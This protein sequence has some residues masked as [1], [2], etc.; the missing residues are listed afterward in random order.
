VDTTPVSPAP[1]RAGAWTGLLLAAASAGC[2]A[3][4]PQELLRYC[5]P[6]RLARGLTVVVPGVRGPQPETLATLD[7]LA[8]GGVDGEIRVFDWSAAAPGDGLANLSDLDRNRA[9]ARRLAAMVLDYRARFPGRPVRLVGHSGG[10]GM[11]LFALEQLPEGPDAAAWTRR[12]CWPRR[13]PPAT[14]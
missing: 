8:D 7:G 6:D 14:T 5:G 12:P 9:W 1:L 3:P 2:A 10:S 11:V 4:T 13:C